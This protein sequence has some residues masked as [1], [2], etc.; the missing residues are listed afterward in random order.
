MLSPNTPVAQ[1]KNLGP[2]SAHQLESVGI[3]TFADL[4][5]AGALLAYKI[6][7]HH[8]PGINTL[9]LYALHGALTDTHWN[10]ISNAEK[11][12][13]KQEASGNLDL[14]FGD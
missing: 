10:A 1:L 4:E 13:L 7:Q 3:H 9:M 11:R 8:F 2:V 5:E 12:R 6:L 14:I